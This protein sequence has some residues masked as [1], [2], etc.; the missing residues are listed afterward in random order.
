[1][2][3]VLCGQAQGRGGSYGRKEDAERLG[4]RKEVACTLWDV[5]AKFKKRADDAQAEFLG[6]IE[7][8]NEIFEEEQAL[9][10][11][12]ED[13]AREHAVLIREKEEV[14]R[15]ISMKVK[16]NKM[17]FCVFLC[18]LAVMVAVLVGVILK[19]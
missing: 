5:V 6:A 12:K 18:M 13:W 15:E 3:R 1:M 19:K 4:F 14:Q 16:D 8:R 7:L 11:E 17:L 10:S 2:P 9:L